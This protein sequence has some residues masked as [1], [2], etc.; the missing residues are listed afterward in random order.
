[1]KEERP[2]RPLIIKKEIKKEVTYPPSELGSMCARDNRRERQ[3]WLVVKQ[4]SS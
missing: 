4:M 1:M 2:R 3:R